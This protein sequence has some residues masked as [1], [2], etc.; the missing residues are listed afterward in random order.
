LDRRT[1]CF[2]ISNTRMLQT[3]KKPFS[4]TYHLHN[5]FLFK[6]RHNAVLQTFLSFKRPCSK[7]IR[8]KNS[9]CIPCHPFLATCPAHR[10][11]T[12]LAY[13]ISLCKSRF[14]CTSWYSKLPT[15]FILRFCYFHK[16]IVWKLKCFKFINT[17]LSLHLL[18]S[19]RLT[20]FSTYLY[21]KDE[22]L[23]P[24]NLHN[25][26]FVSRFKCSVFHNSPNLIS[27]FF[28]SV[29]LRKIVSVGV[30]SVST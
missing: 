19:Q 27:L 14:L 24:G 6:M 16:H 22:R 2:F 8:R 11:F 10:I 29:V 17:L 5:V 15:R 26:K 20:F 7:V 1:W 21:L 12:I 9:V 13:K 28:L 4:S 25:R 23:L 3:V 30:R 18:N